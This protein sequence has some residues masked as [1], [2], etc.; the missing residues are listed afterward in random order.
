MRTARARCLSM[1]RGAI[2]PAASWRFR[3]VASQGETARVPHRRRFGG[4]LRSRAR[5]VLA[6]SRRCATHAIA[7]GGNASCDMGCGAAAAPGAQRTRGVPTREKVSGSS[8]AGRRR[9]ARST[10][11]ASSRTPGPRNQYGYYQRLFE[12]QWAVSPCTADRP[13]RSSFHP[14][15]L[16][17]SRASHPPT[18]CRAHPRRARYRA[19]CRAARR[20]APRSGRAP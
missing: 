19:G 6:R 3:T 9:R 2:W 7:S 1:K 12:D 11:L 17:R 10:L 5:S 8:H 16:E 14:S 4:V 15:E 18:P 20:P 13:A